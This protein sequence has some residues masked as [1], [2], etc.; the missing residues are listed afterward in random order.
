MKLFLSRQAPVEPKQNVDRSCLKEGGGMIGAIATLFAGL[1]ML[2]ACQI[3]HV[4]QQEATAAQAQPEAVPPAAPPSTVQ[5]TAEVMLEPE[6]S[7]YVEE[8]AGAQRGGEVHGAPAMKHRAPPGG[9]Y[10]KVSE[11]VRFP[12]FF[13]G[14]GQLWVD[15][16]SLPVGP[17]RAYDRDGELVSTILMVPLDELNAHNTRD[18]IQGTP[19]PVN[20][21]DMHFTEGHPGVDEP[22]YHIILWHVPQE[23]VATLR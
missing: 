5:T 20:H 10:R 6:E 9:R 1:V 4:P 14:L 15:P 23:R 16:S 8:A 3:H 11:L 19:E 7:A 17:F 18:A 12:D 13:P 2:V 21:I 22:H